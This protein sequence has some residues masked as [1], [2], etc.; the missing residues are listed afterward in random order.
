MHP[1]VLWRLCVR[2]STSVVHACSAVWSN[3]LQARIYIAL[4][5]PILHKCGENTTVLELL[6]VPLGS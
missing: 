3:I 4:H 1:P 2:G 5:F 6:A